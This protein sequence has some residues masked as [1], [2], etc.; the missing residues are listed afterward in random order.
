M[1]EPKVPEA[2]AH[3]EAVMREYS[4][5]GC[6]DSEGLRALDKVYECAA[7]DRKLPKW[8]DNPNPFQIYQSMAGWEIA[9]DALVSAARALWRAL[10]K[11]NLGI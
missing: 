1:M 4:N 8:F 10:V 9:S 2:K 6:R 7:E 11:E 3:M 5:Y